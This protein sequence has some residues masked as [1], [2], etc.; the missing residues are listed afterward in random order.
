MTLLA[1]ENDF[2][3]ACAVSHVEPP[4]AGWHTQPQ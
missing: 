2:K 4:P 1:G 3:E